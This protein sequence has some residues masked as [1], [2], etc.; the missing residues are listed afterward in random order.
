MGW[1]EKR[2]SSTE[3]KQKYKSPVAEKARPPRL[4]LEP[5]KVPW[6]KIWKIK[7]F[8]SMDEYVDE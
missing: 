7:S 2:T 4:N 5:D 3:I 1:R 8:F 6:G